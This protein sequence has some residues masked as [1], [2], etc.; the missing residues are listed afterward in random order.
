MSRPGEAKTTW[1]DTQTE[2]L[3]GN[4]LRA[5]VTLAAAI[6]LLGGLLYLIEH[7]GEQP[8]YRVFNSQP[9]NLRSVTGIL[10]EAFSL[11][12]LG[13]IQLGL[14]ALVATPVARVLFS[15]VAFA[16]ERDWTYVGITLIVLAVLAYS[17][18]GG[19]L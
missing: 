6:V 11:S 2:T 15:I 19:Q 13:L 14:L 10:G 12:G 17:L 3:M 8:D 18:I 1:S 5:G 16:R 7:G 9:A 4:L